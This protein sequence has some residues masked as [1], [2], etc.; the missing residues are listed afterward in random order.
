MRW[1]TVAK[2]LIRQAVRE[3]QRGPKQRQREVE[4]KRKRRQRELELAQKRLAFQQ[5]KRARQQ[6]KLKG[7]Q[8]AAAVVD[9]FNRDLDSLVSLHKHPAKRVDWKGLAE[10]PPPITPRRM[11]VKEDQANQQLAEFNP[12]LFDKLLNRV[13]TKLADLRRQVERAIE[14]DELAFQKALRNQEKRYVRWKR[15]RDLANSIL[16]ADVQAYSK[17]LNRRFP[18]EELDAFKSAVTFQVLDDTTIAVALR[19]NGGRSIPS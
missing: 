17:V 18:F 16:K 9:A 6:R 2:R 10:V 5:K 3:I 8:R 11:S 15:S 4:P 12:G 19:M 14:R 13:E 1:E 7:R